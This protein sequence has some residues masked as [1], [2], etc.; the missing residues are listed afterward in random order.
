MNN[1]YSKLKSANFEEREK[2]R[3]RQEKD[4]RESIVHYN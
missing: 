2:E 3:E 4:K 1:A